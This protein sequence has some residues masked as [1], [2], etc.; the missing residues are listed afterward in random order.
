MS[1]AILLKSV[2]LKIISEKN[3]IKPIASVLDSYG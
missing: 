3:A 2:C 1:T